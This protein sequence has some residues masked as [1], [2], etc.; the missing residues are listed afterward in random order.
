[1]SNFVTQS[2][3]NDWEE[4]RKER[5]FRF[6]AAAPPD[7]LGY[8][9]Q[10]KGVISYTTYITMTENDQ[11]AWWTRFLTKHPQVPIEDEME[12]EPPPVTSSGNTGGVQRPENHG[13]QSSGQFAYI[14]EGL[15]DCLPKGEQPNPFQKCQ[16]DCRRL[17]EEYDNECAKLKERLREHYRMKC[18][19][20]PHCPTT[21][22]NYNP[23]PCRDPSPMMPCMEG[24]VTPMPYLPPQPRPMNRQH[25]CDCFGQGQY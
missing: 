22:T 24:R 20:R 3:Y 11:N 6:A 5:W 21:E 16:D 7:G 8:R 17:Q 2:A 25:R 15:E 12:V 9:D 14:N 4:E 18:G 19:Q 1:M 10:E 23:C 13:V